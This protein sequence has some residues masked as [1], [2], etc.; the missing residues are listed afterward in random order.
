MTPAQRFISE[1]NS[2]KDVPDTLSLTPFLPHLVSLMIGLVSPITSFAWDTPTYGNTSIDM[3]DTLAFGG[4]AVR[5]SSDLL[6]TWQFNAALTGLGGIQSNATGEAP[7]N[8][9][10]VSNAQA[11]ISKSTGLFQLFAVAGYYSLP[12]LATSYL[13]AATQTQ[14][15]YRQLPIAIGT[16]APNENWSLNFGNLF[17]LGGAE[18]TFSYEN[19]NIQRGLLWGQTNSVT[20]GMQLNYQKD[21]LSSSVAWTDGAYSGKYNWL[22]VSV[23]YQATQK[24]AVTAI[25]NGSLSGNTTNTTGTPLLQNNSQITNLLFSYS[26]DTWGLTPYLQYTVVPSN[27]SIGITGT[28]STQG[29]GLLA[30]YRIT[31]LVEGQP[32][33]HNISL[34]FRLEYMNSFGNSGTNANNLLYGP[35]SAAWSATVTPTFQNGSWFLRLEGSYVRATNYSNGSAFGVSGNTPAQSRFLVE[36]GL[37]Y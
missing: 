11:V 29:A 15:T 33:K 14:N 7:R 31:P 32:A 20:R 8:Y 5:F 12:D 30:T 17:A 27:P 28:S 10:D 24:S 2:V 19:I 36:A 35:N 34:P 21:A 1:K 25:W 16:I 3:G 6:G 9:G 37:L 13:R 4:D 23:A 26:G 18:G 22:G